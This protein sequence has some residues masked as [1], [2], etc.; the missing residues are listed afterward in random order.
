MPIY[1]S[2]AELFLIARAS[3]EYGQKKPPAQEEGSAGGQDYNKG[4]IK[5]WRKNSRKQPLYNDAAQQK[6]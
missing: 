6:N 3:F 1:H 5:V 4:A 2:V